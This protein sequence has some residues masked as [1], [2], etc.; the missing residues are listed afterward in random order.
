VTPDTTAHTPPAFTDSH[1]HLYWERF[2]PDYD[3]VVERMRQSGV[4]RVMNIGID[5][6]TSRQVVELARTHKGWFASAGIHPTD[7]H[8][9]PAD[10]ET[11]LRALIAEGPV[12]AIGE[13]GLD[14][15]WIDKKPETTAPKEVQHRVFRQHLDLA[16]SVGLPVVI[17]CREAMSDVR[18]ILAEYK[19]VVRGVMHCFDGTADDAEFLA[20]LGWW[21]S[22]AGPLTYPSRDGLR[23]AAK[24][25]P[26][27]K[28]LIETDAPFLPPQGKR[29]QRNE[30]SYVQIVAEKIAELKGFSVEDVARAT[31][32]N[33]L[34]MVGAEDE[35]ART[36]PVFAYRIRDAI[37]VNL[38]NRCTARCVFCPRV[39][40]PVVTGYDLGMKKRDE[41][42]PDEAKASIEAIAATLASEGKTAS[43]IVFCGFGEPTLRL[44]ELLEIGRWAKAKGW[45][46]RLNTIGH[47]NLIAGRNVVPELATAIDIASVSLN[48]HTEELF[49]KNCLPA[50]RSRAWQGMLDFIRDGAAAFARVDCTALDGFEGCEPDKVKALAESLGARFRGRVYEE[51]GK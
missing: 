46:V 26:I 29:G 8:T 44:D 24:A 30:P 7:T 11:Q 36:E 23:D 21:I 34:R 12:H 9:A 45:P 1:C 31:T 18:A 49:L 13:T 20:D 2:A 27:E 17:H 25:I 43:E 3:A 38:T 16:A 35:L 42:T 5:L 10:W 50:F 15:Y 6:A 14:Y 39:E 51:I 32:R 28:I 37:Y 47:A 4:T 19:D 33:F 48:F 22:F 40:D 41:P